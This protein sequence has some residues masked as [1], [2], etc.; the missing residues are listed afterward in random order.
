MVEKQDLETRTIILQNLVVDSNGPKAF[1][2]FG[3][4]FLVNKQ[5]TSTSP[6]ELYWMCFHYFFSEKTLL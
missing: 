5:K 3:K 1:C 2:I 6:R 4:Q